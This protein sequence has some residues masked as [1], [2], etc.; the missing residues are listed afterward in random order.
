MLPAANNRAVF[1]ARAMP[2]G[3]GWPGYPSCPVEET[4]WRAGPQGDLV[5]RETCL[6]GQC[7]DGHV[8]ASNAL[9]TPV[10]SA[11]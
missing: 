3:T 4:N 2:N 6:Q 1:G 8:A 7:T 11:A 5:I 10:A 9:P